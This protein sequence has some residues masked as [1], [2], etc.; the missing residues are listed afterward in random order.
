[1]SVHAFK[2]PR[3]EKPSA[4]IIY[5]D[6]PMARRVLEKNTRNRPISELH[7]Q[8]RRDNVRLRRE[9]ANHHA[10]AEAERAESA[11]L[12][13]ENQGFAVDWANANNELAALKDALAAA[14]GVYDCACG[15]VW[16][17]ADEFGIEDYAALNRWLGRHLGDCAKLLC[18]QNLALTTELAALK[19]EQ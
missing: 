16:E 8:L 15:S 11:R 10:T 4:S 19:G 9:A 7:V 6:P 17:F 3:H 12:R 5:I 18:A 13:R 14:V 1:M 2:D